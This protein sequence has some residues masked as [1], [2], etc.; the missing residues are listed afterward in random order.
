MSVAQDGDEQVAMDAEEYLQPQGASNISMR[1]P[2]PFHH[3]NYSNGKLEK[4]GGFLYSKLL[5]ISIATA[6]SIS[7]AILPYSLWL[8]LL[9]WLIY[10]AN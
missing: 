3:P 4:V 1:P 7:T 10:Y 2:V 8:C 9:S 6:V 5:S